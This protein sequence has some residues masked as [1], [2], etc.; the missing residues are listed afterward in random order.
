[1][2]PPLPQVLDAYELGVRGVLRRPPARDDRPGRAPQRP[3]RRAEALPANA[4][5]PVQLRLGARPTG[6]GFVDGFGLRYS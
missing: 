1:M 4:A 6:F 3:V 2:R 5:D